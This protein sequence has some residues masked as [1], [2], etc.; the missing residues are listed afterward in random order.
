MACSYDQAHA[1]QD[2]GCAWCAG[3][4]IMCVVDMQE[5]PAYRYI[6]ASVAAQTGYPLPLQLGMDNPLSAESI[7][8]QGSLCWSYPN[9]AVVLARSGNWANRIRSLNFSCSCTTAAAA[10]YTCAE[11]ATHTR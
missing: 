1:T 7:L 6:A 3:V 5:V 10:R 8:S 11:L 2:L 4:K 9:L